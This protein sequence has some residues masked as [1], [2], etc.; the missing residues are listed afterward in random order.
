ML[1]KEGKKRGRAGKFELAV[2]QALDK[3]AGNLDFLP[4]LTLDKLLCLH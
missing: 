3:D 2:S 1:N 4:A